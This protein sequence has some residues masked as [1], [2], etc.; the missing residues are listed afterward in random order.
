MMEKSDSAADEDPYLIVIDGMDECED[1]QGITSFIIHSIKFFREHPHIPLRLF[2]TSRVEEH[3]RTHIGGGTGV[4]HFFDLPSRSNQGDVERAMKAT[5][6]HAKAHNR[7]LQAL[8]PL[9]PPK[10][11]LDAL[12]TY[13][14]GSFIFMST[15][16][17]FILWGSGDEDPRTPEDR[18]K[19]ALTIDPGIDSVYRNVLSRARSL[20]H[21]LAIISTVAYLQTPLSISAIAALLGLST[22]EVIR[23]LV[24]LQAILQVPGQDDE[25]VTFFHTSLRDFL[26][27]PTRSGEFHSLPS[28]HAHLTHRCLDV[29]VGTEPTANSECCTYAM[30]YWS[31]HLKIA[32]CWDDLLNLDHVLD[33]EHPYNPIDR[34]DWTGRS[35]QSR[36]GE[37]RPI[38]FTLLQPQFATMFRNLEASFPLS[39]GQVRI[40]VAFSA[41]PKTLFTRVY[42]VQYRS[43]SLQQS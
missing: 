8:G 36:R 31:A 17:K 33:N 5:L 4:V 11:D 2:I 43:I 16:T 40:P 15:I 7:A 34:G 37:G 30:L 41:T 10:D 21:F 27:D 25:P 12:V 20:P 23:V 13:C 22:Y 29:L 3:I 32:A 14:D 18:L 39:S 6:E 9:W 1:K 42:P 19:L 38:V 28:H 24:T 35:S 26:A